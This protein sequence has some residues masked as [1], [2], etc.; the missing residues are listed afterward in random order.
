MHRLL[1]AVSVCS[2]LV[3]AA[4]II[5]IFCAPLASAQTDDFNIRRIEFGYKIRSGSENI[6]GGFGGFGNI[7]G[8]PQKWGM[9]TVHYNSKPTWADDITFKYFVLVQPT[10][11]RT[12]MLT[13][14]LTYVSVY[15]GLDHLAYMFIH[16]NTLARYGKVKRIMVEIWYKGVLAD[17]KQWPSKTASRWWNQ[18]APIQGTLR[19]RFYTPFEHD[20]EVHEE[21]VKIVAPAPY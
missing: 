2:R 17:S 3:C 4:W 20:Y 21:D 14:N 10:K 6:S 11:G 7:G 13:G 18:V 12:S 8:F 16:P 9:I 15:Q 19:P 1:S 5:G